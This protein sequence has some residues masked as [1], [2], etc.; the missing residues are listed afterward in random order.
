MSGDGEDFLTNALSGFEVPQGETAVDVTGKTLSAGEFGN[1]LVEQDLTNIFHPLEGSTKVD[2]TG[3][4]LH[5]VD[6]CELFEPVESGQPVDRDTG[7]RALKGGQSTDLKDIFAAKGSIPADG[8]L[9]GLPA[10]TFTCDTYFRVWLDTSGSMNTALGY[11]RPA[12]AIIKK[13]FALVFYGSE[14][15]AGN[16]VSVSSTSDEKAFDWLAS[17]LD[18]RNTAADPPKEIQIAFINESSRGGPGSAQ[19]YIDRWNT[20]NDLGGVK[21]GAIGGVTAG[22]GGVVGAYPA[23]LRPYLYGDSEPNNLSEYG[24]QDFWDIGDHTPTSEYVEMLVRWLNIPTKPTELKPETFADGSG[25]SQTTVKWNFNDYICGRTAEPGGTGGYTRT[26]KNWT[27]QVSTD[28]NGDV[29]VDTQSYTSERPE[30]Y[31]YTPTLPGPMTYY[32]RLTAVGETDYTDKSSSW[33][34]C[35]LKDTPPVLTMLGD[36]SITVE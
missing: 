14:Y 27:V 28:S 16:Y 8:T 20:V 1:I 32:C 9:T 35:D 4:L 2:E 7:Y 31:T 19:G 15:N 10:G 26:Q 12:A 18:S 3:L 11:I 30:S 24:V 6:L 33:V 23:Y 29:I 34:A 21:Y 5:G 25:T 17:A 13:Y 22:R 36:A